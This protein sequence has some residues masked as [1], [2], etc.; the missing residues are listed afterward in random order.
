M[1]K[2][3]DEWYAK[4][5]EKAS[6]YNNRLYLENLFFAHKSDDASQY[7]YTDAKGDI[8]PISDWNASILDGKFILANPE[9]GLFINRPQDLSQEQL[10]TIN[11][12]LREHPSWIVR[13]D[14]GGFG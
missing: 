5:Y 14:L 4:N 2:M 6:I 10:D 8:K 11:E 3:P 1:K 7:S 13:P 9:G 12:Y